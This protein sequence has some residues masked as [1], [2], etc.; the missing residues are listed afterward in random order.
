MIPSNTS[1]TE[2]SKKLPLKFFFAKMD[3][4]VSSGETAG[5]PASTTAQSQACAMGEFPCMVSTATRAPC[6]LALFTTSSVTLVSPE[7]EPTI[8]EI[9]WLHTW[10]ANLANKISF[11]ACLHQ[12]HC[13]SLHRKQTTTCPTHKDT[14]C[15]C[16]FLLQ[17]FCISVL[18]LRQRSVAAPPIP[19]VPFASRSYFTPP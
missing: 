15:L 11:T 4:S 10:C 12:P 6:P 8:K 17:R 1:V 19:P 2:A 7:P 14:F 16:D 18:Q 3:A 5:I 9:T 13:K